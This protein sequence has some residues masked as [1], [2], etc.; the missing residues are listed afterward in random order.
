[1]PEVLA[2]IRDR[3][4]RR[5]LA[6][7][8]CELRV[9]R[10]RPELLRLG[11]CRAGPACGPFAPACR[12]QGPARLPRP[13]PARRPRCSPPAVTEFSKKTGDYPSLSAADLQVLA[14]TCQL[15][16]EIDGPGCLRWEP[17]DKVGPARAPG[18]GPRFQRPRRRPVL[19]PRCGSAPPRGT[20]RPPC[21]SPASTCP[22]R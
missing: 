19:P 1:M 13:G 16:T 10:P 4:A 2:E 22:P 11:E 18:T 21:T 20:P 5:R 9:R 15:Q 14:L 8:P 12:P 7:L 6:A 17:Q 3:P